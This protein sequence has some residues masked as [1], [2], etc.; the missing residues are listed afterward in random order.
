MFQ[1]KRVKIDE[2]KSRIC[3]FSI[4]GSVHIRRTSSVCLPAGSRPV[5]YRQ[6]IFAQEMGSS[7][8]CTFVQTVQLRGCARDL[9][10]IFESEASLYE[11]LLYEC[12][13]AYIW[14]NDAF[15]GKKRSFRFKGNNQPGKSA[16]QLSK[17]HKMIFSRTFTRASI[18]DCRKFPT[19]SLTHANSNIEFDVINSVETFAR[20][21]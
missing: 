8:V 19:H 11:I 16:G 6:D 13:V 17:S 20:G 1:H 9:C 3:R 12:S 2:K 7:I 4:S 15:R 14:N 10:L 21:T 18:I 5:G